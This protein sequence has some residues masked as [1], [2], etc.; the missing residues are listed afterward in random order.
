M[1]EALKFTFVPE[2]LLNSW[3]WAHWAIF[4]LLSLLSPPCLLPSFSKV[5]L[6][7]LWEMEK[8][9]GEQTLG[10]PPAAMLW[11]LLP[12]A[13]QQKDHSLHLGGLKQ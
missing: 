2:C 9:I 11:Q 4:L 10:F 1:G 3:A 13:A 12:S 6:W 5:S 8:Q 7:H